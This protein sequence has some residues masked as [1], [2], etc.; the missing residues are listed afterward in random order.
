MN[1]SQA[2]SEGAGPMPQKG[3][4]TEWLGQRPPPRTRAPALGLLESPGYEA[5]NAI[6][7]QDLAP[8][9]PPS[10]SRARSP[11]SETERDAHPDAQRAS[12]EWRSASEPFFC[13]KVANVN[14]AERKSN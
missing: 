14:F 3:K 8:S 11:T 9:L 4:L 2:L 7:A 12:D 10:G 13:V 5:K 6:S 1:G